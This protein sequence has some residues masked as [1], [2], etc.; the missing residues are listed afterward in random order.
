[1]SAAS[2]QDNSNAPWAVGSGSSLW[3]MGFLPLPQNNKLLRTDTLL[4]ARSWG[5]Q[6]SMTR[7]PPLWSGGPK[8]RSPCGSGGNSGNSTSKG[9]G[10]RG[11]T[12]VAQPLGARRGGGE[13]EG[14]PL[15]GCSRE[16]WDL[17]RGFVLSGT[18]RVSPRPWLCRARF[19]ALLLSAGQPPAQGA[20]KGATATHGCG[21]SVEFGAGPQPPAN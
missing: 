18:D 1:M 7:H 12:K 11:L 14:F 17:Q 20:S 21:S 19:Q 8:C 4:W 9:P 6:R 5:P 10:Q 13:R 2:S 16:A 15:S 3:T